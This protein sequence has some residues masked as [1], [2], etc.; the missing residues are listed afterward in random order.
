MFSRLQVSAFLA[1]A[2]AVTCHAASVP[3]AAG[4]VNYDLLSAKLSTTA[5]IYLPGSDA[6]DGLVARWSNFSTPVANVVVVPSTEN[7]I[8]QIVRLS[9]GVRI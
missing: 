7:D 4:S 8:V 2:A 9:P 6:F 3:R 5:Q 1:L